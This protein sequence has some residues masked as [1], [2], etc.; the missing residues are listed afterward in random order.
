M[1]YAQE[2][3]DYQGG[4]EDINVATRSPDQVINDLKYLFARPGQMSA[5]DR[6]FYIEDL[7]LTS[8]QAAQA[9]RAMVTAAVLGD[10]TIQDGPA[11]EIVAQQGIA[12]TSCR[13]RHAILQLVNFSSTHTSWESIRQKRVLLRLKKLNL[14]IILLA[15][16]ETTLE[17]AAVTNPPEAVSLYF[18]QLK[19]TVNKLKEVLGNTRLIM[20]NKPRI[21]VYLPRQG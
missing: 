17:T 16:G 20:E 14:D 12:R 11:W 4:L 9:N 21:I 7:Q 18:K 3:Y 8:E 13:H 19:L 10:T 1:A 15:V 5:T 2:N 6:Q